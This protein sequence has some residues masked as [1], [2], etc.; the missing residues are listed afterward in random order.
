MFRREVEQVLSEE[1]EE[2]KWGREGR[3]RRRGSCQCG[4]EGV[5]RAAAAAVAFL[6]ASHSSS[7]RRAEQSSE[8]TWPWQISAA[9]PAR[10]ALFVFH[11]FFPPAPDSPSPISSR[12]KNYGRGAI[13]SRSCSEPEGSQQFPL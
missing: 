2:A 12:E 9:T 7:R 8:S 5:G 11:P 3:E 10:N 4:G 13:F 6:V 1:I